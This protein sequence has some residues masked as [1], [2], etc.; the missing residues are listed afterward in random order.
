MEWQLDM[1]PASGSPLLYSFKNTATGAGCF[2][3]PLQSGTNASGSYASSAPA[4]SACGNPSELAVFQNV[5]YSYNAGGPKDGDWSFFRLL[6]TGN[7]ASDGLRGRLRLEP[8]PASSPP[9]RPCVSERSWSP[10]NCFGS[11][12]SAC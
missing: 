1:Y 7:P 6:F 9:Q 3:S 4:G 11:P 10:A 12:G 2:S 5:P 8:S